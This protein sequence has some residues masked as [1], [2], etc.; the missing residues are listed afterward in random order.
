M[1]VPRAH[2][3]EALRGPAEEF[4]LIPKGGRRWGIRNPERYLML[5]LNTRGVP[6]H[7]EPDAVHYPVVDARCEDGERF[8]VVAGRKDCRPKGLHLSFPECEW[9]YYNGYPHLRN[10]AY[11]PQNKTDAGSAATRSTSQG[12]GWRAEGLL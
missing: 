11:R 12:V 10:P 8:C 7:T 6:V 2:L 4:Y 1:L 3:H 9:A 5:A